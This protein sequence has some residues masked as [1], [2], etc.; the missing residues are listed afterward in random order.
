M[1]GTPRT[2]ILPDRA[3]P[4]RAGPLLAFL[5]GGTDR[6]AE[7]S[8]AQ[9]RRLDP[10]V[11]E[12]LVVAARD[13]HLRGLRVAVTD[14][15]PETEERLARLGLTPDILPRGPSAEARA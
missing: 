12:T 15:P 9:A 13:W 6:D 3:D 7:V 1:P 4:G 2:F 11:I 5:R 14:V 8:L 10:R